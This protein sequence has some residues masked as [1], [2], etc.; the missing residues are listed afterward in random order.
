MCL[1]NCNTVKILKIGRAENIAVIILTIE[2]SGFT[3]ELCP[4]NADE[5]VNS[6]DPDQTAPQSGSAL[7]CWGLTVRKLRIIA[8]Y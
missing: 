7:F 1:V 4:S 6:V 5:M 8:V 3:I 2:Q